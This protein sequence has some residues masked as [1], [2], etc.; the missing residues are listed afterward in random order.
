MLV[1]KLSKIALAVLA[2]FALS[3][4]GGSHSH[5]GGSGQEQS[6]G[7]E[8]EQSGGS[9][10]EQ[11]GGQDSKDGSNSLASVSFSCDSTMT[12]VSLFKDYKGAVGEAATD[13]EIPEYSHTVAIDFDGLKYSVDGGEQISLTDS[14]G[15]PD[16]I[17]FVIGDELVTVDI[18][19]AEGNFKFS[20]S[21]T[22]ERSIDV[23]AAKNA[24]IGLELDGAVIKGGN[25]PAIAIGP[26]TATVYVTLKGENTLSDSREF[27]IGYSSAN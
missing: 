12:G 20:L 22:L 3:S 15:L 19:G 9:E 14:S 24:K 18:S 10:Q 4:C 2:A 7:S 8:Q 25:Y 27:G 17:G 13:E 26:K 5:S 23:T 11:S 16:G 21:G 1:S 6:G